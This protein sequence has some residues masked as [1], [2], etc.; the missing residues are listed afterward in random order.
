MADAGIS[1][2]SA[3]RTACGGS[4]DGSISF[5]G[6]G[7]SGAGVIFSAIFMTGVR[8][9]EVYEAEEK[10]DQDDGARHDGGDGPPARADEV[11]RLV[12]LLRHLLDAVFQ[13][14]SLSLH[15]LV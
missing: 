4:A 1:T 7:S 14:A 10:L 2:G 11:V 13:V 3:R 12:R 8:G 6:T 5:A 9:S 15:L